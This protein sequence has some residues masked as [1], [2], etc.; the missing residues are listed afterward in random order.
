MG[1]DVDRRANEGQTHTNTQF[2]QY[3]QEITKINN[4]SKTDSRC[5]SVE[6]FANNVNIFVA[7]SYCAANIR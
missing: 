5:G 7:K 4:R 6:N 2:F 3:P 1:A